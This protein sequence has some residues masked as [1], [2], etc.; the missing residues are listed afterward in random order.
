MT[1]REL[2]GRLAAQKKQTVI[3]KWFNT[4]TD[5][6]LVA[7]EADIISL[8]DED[9]TAKYVFSKSAARDWLGLKGSKPVTAKEDFFTYRKPTSKFAKKT[10]TITDDTYNALREEIN[11]IADNHGFSAKY[12]TDMIISAGIEASKSMH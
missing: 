10:I 3:W 7:I 8:S 11:F 2:D 12:C 1:R 9:F 4:S 6:D 5:E